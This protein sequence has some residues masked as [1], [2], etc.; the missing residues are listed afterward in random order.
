MLPKDRDDITLKHD[1]VI[2][3]S[4][5]YKNQ[6]ESDDEVNVPEKLRT[7]PFTLEFRIHR[8]LEKENDFQAVAYNIR[9][10]QVLTCN[11][12]YLRL[13][14]L[15]ARSV[16]ISKTLALPSGTSISHI[17]Y[18]E[19]EDVYMIIVNGLS[20]SLRIMSSA[21][22]ATFV[23]LATFVGGKCSTG[24]LHNKRQEVGYVEYP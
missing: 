11:I 23:D 16:S 5:F 15:D 24:A 2:K 17:S 6:V 3:R 10:Q 8:G 18:N 12:Q 20:G 1:I 7:I 4:A 13:W 19:L 14:S 21:L 9:R 22:D